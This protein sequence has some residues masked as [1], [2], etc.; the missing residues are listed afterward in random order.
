MVSD[1][2]AGITALLT[3]HKVPNRWLSARWGPSGQV[4][5]LTTLLEMAEARGLATGV[6]TTTRVTD[7]TPAAAY[8]HVADRDDEQEIAAALISGGSP[9]R[10]GD[11]VEVILGGGLDYFLPLEKGGVRMDGRDLR[12]EMI[13]AGYSFVDSEAAMKKA[14]RGGIRRLLGLFSGSDMEF[15]ADRREGLA[16]PS[17]AQMTRAALQ[18]LRRDPHGYFLLVES[19]LIDR[20]H[21]RNNAY[22]AIDEVLALDDAVG[23][24]LSLVGETASIYVTADHDHTMV[25]AGYA[26]VESDVF[27]QAGTD[28]EGRAYTALLYANGPSARPGRW[29][30]VT[31][32]TVGSASFRERAGIPLHRETHGGMDVPLFI[33]GP[34]GGERPPAASID[35]TEVFQ[36]LAVLLP[37]GE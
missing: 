34:E 1:S 9:P 26:P 19:G 14:V 32:S 20:A 6:V 15:E 29:Q 11:G 13:A 31:S 12:A 10:I 28:T 4:E 3:G 16:E 17:L 37:R 8:A 2:A 21:H 27:T 35:N 7:A 25:I 23:E 5:P 18:I 33:F 24:A 30:R 36:R 22:R